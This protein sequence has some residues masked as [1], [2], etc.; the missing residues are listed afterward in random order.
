MDF[1]QPASSTAFPIQQTAWNRKG[2]VRKNQSR[3][4]RPQGESGKVMGEAKG[5]KRKTA[6]GKRQQSVHQL[7]KEGG[8]VGRRMQMWV[9]VL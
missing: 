7:Q 2:L 5:I 8:A 1:V 6:T 9:R 3:I 4:N